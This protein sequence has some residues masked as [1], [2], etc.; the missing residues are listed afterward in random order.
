MPEPAH[1]RGARPTQA[2]TRDLDAA[3]D[4]AGSDRERLA[5]LVAQF[6]R[7]DLD[8]DD[9]KRLMA[10]VEPV[11]GREA[12]T[13]LCLEASPVFEAMAEEDELAG[14]VTLVVFG[15]QFITNPDRRP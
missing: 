7:A 14:G 3:I 2:E 4:R 11:L 6:A 5:E 8:L 12:V 13:D 15:G 10:R 1:S 9:H